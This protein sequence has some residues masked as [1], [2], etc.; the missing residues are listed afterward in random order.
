MSMQSILSASMSVSRMQAVQS[1]QTKVEGRIGVLKAEIKSDGGNE[2]KEKKVGEL[3]EQ[4]ASLTGSLMGDLQEV[5]ESL[6]PDE[7]NKESEGVEKKPENMDSVELSK[8]PDGSTPEKKAVTG[9]PV[10][11]SP[12]GEEVKAEAQK[13]G[14]QVDVK[15]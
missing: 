6:K 4:A 14:K 12:E 9:D 11:Y 15:A 5:N 10:T 2:Q 1:A 7:D 13:T 8:R 3:E